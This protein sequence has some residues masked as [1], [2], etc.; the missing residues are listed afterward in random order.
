MIIG[1]GAHYRAILTL[2]PAVDSRKLEDFTRI[3]KILLAAV[4]GY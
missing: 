3:K 4:D 1:D 2:L